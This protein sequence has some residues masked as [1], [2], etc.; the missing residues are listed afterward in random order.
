MT[1]AETAVE[2]THADVMAALAAHAQAIEVLAEQQRQLAEVM[3]QPPVNDG[4]SLFGDL[5]PGQ[6]VRVWGEFLEVVEKRTDTDMWGHQRLM[7][8]VRDDN[9]VE[10]YYEAGETEPFTVAG[11]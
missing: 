10:H 6:Q 9:G 8:V 1:V 4:L 3:R 7:L 2:P 5:T 11:F